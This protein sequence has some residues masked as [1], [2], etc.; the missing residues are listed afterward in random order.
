LL[1]CVFMIRDDRLLQ[2]VA[3]ANPRDTHDIVLEDFVSNQA[4]GPSEEEQLRRCHE[5]VDRSLVELRTD[6]AWMVAIEEVLSGL[7]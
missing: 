6:N 5:A 3:P 1:Y 7:K 2:F 4:H